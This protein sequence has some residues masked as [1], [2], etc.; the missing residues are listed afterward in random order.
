MDQE[1]LD[2]L[3]DSKNPRKRS[4]ILKLF[5]GPQKAGAQDSTFSKPAPVPNTEAAVTSTATKN[6]PQSS[7]FHAR[8]P[9]HGRGSHVD[10][11]HGQQVGPKHHRE[12]VTDPFQ[13]AG[14]V[15]NG[16]GGEKNK[17]FLGESTQYQNISLPGRHTNNWG[18]EGG[19]P[20]EY[21]PSIFQADGAEIQNQ[22]G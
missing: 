5:R 12:G 7:N 19:M 10:Q 4:R 20:E 16:F 13:R 9:V 22:V 17:H 18:V 1:K 15:H 6:H 8:A 3:F 11:T 14:T 2:A 21:R